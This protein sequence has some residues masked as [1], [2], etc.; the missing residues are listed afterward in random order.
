MADPIHQFVIKPIVPFEIGGVDLSFTNSALWMVIAAV[1]STLFLLMASRKQ[2]IIPGR[3]QVFSELL[4][5]FI[6]GMVRENI[7]SHG[8]QYFPLVFTVFIVV[9]MGNVLGLIP[10]SFTY[11]SHVIVTGA[12]AIS[13]F[14]IVTAFGFINHGLG[15]LK[16]F[17]PP[18]VPLP[19]QFILVPLELL[20]FLVRPF[21]LALRLF[22]NMMAGHLMLKVFSG[23]SVMLI[24][25]GAAGF[26]PA[27][28][29]MIFNTALYALELLVALLQAYIFAILTCIY[30]KDTVDLHH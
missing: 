16:L 20:S 27:L 2:A 25:L 13:I 23:F 26:F 4:Y 5:E 30:L 11:T 3:V 14:V 15:F 21:T 9:L 6:A 8:R 29:P 28:V 18:G 1:V 10:G 7:G 17:A 24:G 12:L 22:A 19:L